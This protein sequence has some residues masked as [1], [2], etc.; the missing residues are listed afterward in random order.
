MAEEDLRQAAKD[1]DVASV[2]KLLLAGTKQT[3][4]EVGKTLIFYLLACL[5]MALNI[6][7]W[8]FLYC[9]RA[10]LPSST[11][12][13]VPEIIQNKVNFNEVRSQPRISLLQ[14]YNM[15]LFSGDITLPKVRFYPFVA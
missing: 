6:F 2:R 5:A 4:N 11:L 8:H 9:C 3:E 15:L 13:E 1:G 14:I 7:S 10:Y 12:P